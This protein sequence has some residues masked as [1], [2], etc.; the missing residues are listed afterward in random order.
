MFM[1][2]KYL[3]ALQLLIVLFIPEDF[4]FLFGEVEITGSR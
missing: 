2:L 4:E 1:I 3:L